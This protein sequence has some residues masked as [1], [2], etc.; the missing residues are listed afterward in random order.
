MKMQ[1]IMLERISLGALII[2][3]GI[4]FFLESVDHTVKNI[5]EVEEYLGAEVF[6]TISELRK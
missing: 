2:A 4:A 1:G 5:A 3:L 6:A